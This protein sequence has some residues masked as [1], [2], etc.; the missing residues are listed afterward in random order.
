M[1]N[2]WIQS[3][4]VLL[5]LT[6]L[7]MLGSSRVWKCIRV[8]AVQGVLLAALIV[9]LHSDSLNGHVLLLAL[10]NLFV[11]TFLFPWILV[12]A[13]RRADV[14]Q[15]VEPLIG[16]GP[17]L[18]IGTLLMPLSLWLGT[19][20]PLPD[21]LASSLIVP[22]ALFTML[23][24]LFLLVSRKKAITQVLSYLLLENGITVFGVALLV[25]VPCSSNSAP[26]SICSAPS[27]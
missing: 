17:S 12:R 11:K 6:D 20:L 9:A 7:V 1:T 8:I 5:I 13:I 3:L 19:R 4:L 26:C 15:A 2:P 16:F 23:V 10:G 14:D 18:L 24:G 25:K 27:S 21:A 22:V